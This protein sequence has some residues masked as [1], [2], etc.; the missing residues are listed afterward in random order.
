MNVC[1]SRDVHGWVSCSGSA[2]DGPGQNTYAV[3]L[4]T[5]SALGSREASVSLLSLLTRRSNQADQPWVTLWDGDNH[6]HVQTQKTAPGPVTNTFYTFHK[7]P[8]ITFAVIS[9]IFLR[10]SHHRSSSAEVRRRI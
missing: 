8:I 2:P 4:A 5:R 10:K 9:A 6:V 7:D 1:E 3:S